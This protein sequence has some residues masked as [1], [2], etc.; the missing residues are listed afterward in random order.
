MAD[1]DD[2]GVEAAEEGPQGLKYQVCHD[3]SQA[4]IDALNVVYKG[5]LKDDDQLAV[6]HCW[7][8]EKEEYLP[9]NMKLEYIRE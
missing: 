8:A 4:S 7:K 2:Y 3:G 6:A 9:Y 5:L 1:E